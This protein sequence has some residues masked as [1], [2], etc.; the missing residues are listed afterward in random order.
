MRKGI[1]LILAVAMTGTLGCAKNIVKTGH[2]EMKH[3]IEQRQVYGVFGLVPTRK[4]ATTDFCQAGELAK[5]VQKTTFG[6]ALAALFTFYMYTPRTLEVT[7]A[8]LAHRQ[9]GAQQK[10]GK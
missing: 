6:N 4:Y 1:V 3:S 9:P 7:C 8:Q 2:L 5:V 10:G